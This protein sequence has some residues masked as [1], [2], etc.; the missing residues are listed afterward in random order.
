MNA[1]VIIWG[2]LGGTALA[3]AGVHMFLWLLDRR[4]WA[5]LAFFVL[6]ISITAIAVTE[7]GM[8]HASTPAEFGR[9][10]RW[11]HVPNFF[12][13]SGI[14][15]FVRLQF[16]TGRVWLGTTI[17]AIRAIQLGLNF[18]LEVNANWK[19]I[20]SLRTI[21]F[22]GEQVSVVGRAVPQGFQPIITLANVLLLIYVADALRAALHRG[23]PD[24]RRKAGVICG[25][26]LAYLVIS[27]GAGQLIVYGIVQMPVVIS[28]PFIIIM[29][30]ISYEL[31]RDIVASTRA[32]REA[33]RLRN[34]L[35]HIGRVNTM[36]QLSASLAHEI[37]QPL[38]AILLNARAARKMIQ[39][40][41]P[42]LQEF[43]AILDDISTEDLHAANIIDRARELIRN[44]TTASEAVSIRAIAKE[45]FA[46]VR[47]DA[48]DRR[49]T[50]ETAVPDNLPAIRGDRVQLSQVLLNLIMNGFDAVSSSAG[51]ER[52]VVVEAHGG[53][54]ELEVAVADSGTGI[55]ANLLPTI[56]ESFVT[57]KPNGLGI[58]LS[59]A[60]DIVERHGGRIWAEN[61]PRGGATFRF[62]LPL[63]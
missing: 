40:G 30:A 7:V 19:E 22:L 26:L 25:G 4:I 56:F 62:T 20:S 8:M 10:V 15:C 32:F 17:I 9:W 23:D 39:N 29:L 45:V 54:R 27:S 1:V 46:L 6:A 2:A 41:K 61:N 55:D 3:I 52:R 42:D 59:V 48:I 11:F 13:I 16:G 36:T 12:L 35:A 43:A 31:G 47:N 57:T 53:Q 37:N 14:V 60:R 21:T 63:A 33:A 49:I 24:L 38:T 5:N 18:L 28:P 34:D 58:G 51:K 50:L 44:K